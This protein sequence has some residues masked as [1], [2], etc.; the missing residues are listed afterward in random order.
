MLRVI[1]NHR[2]AAYGEA[3]GY[4]GLHDPPRRRSTP[5]AAP[6]SAGRGGA[7]RLGR[8]AGARRAARLP[9]RAGH[10]DRADRHDRPGHGLRHHRDRARLRA[11]EVQE[12]GRRRLLQDHQPD[13]AGGARDARLHARGRSRTSSRYAVGRGTLAGRARHQPRGAARQGLHRRGS[14]E[15]RGA[16]ADAFDIKFAFNPWTLGEELLH[17]RRSASPTRSSTTPAF[18]LLARARLHARARSRP[19]TTFCCGTMTRRGRAAPEGRAPAVFDCANPCGRIGKRFLSAA[20][21]HPD[22]GGGPAVHLAAPSRKTINMPNAATIEDVQGRLHAVLAA[23]PQGATP[24]TATAPSSRQPLA[25][26]AGRRR[27]RT[28]TDEELPRD[29]GQRVA[30]VVERIVEK[31]VRTARAAQAARPP[32]GLHP[33][34]GGRRPQGLPAH[35]RVRGR[36][37]SARSSSTCTRKA[38]PSAR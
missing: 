19:P 9:Q 13:R 3:P 26:H 7:R 2:R 20:E 29:A 14:G 22:D 12:A 11:G 16:L 33:E 5:P 15:G 4:E 28:T 32:Q 24:S 6:T 23:R 38:R 31:V 21:P 35:R 1:R 25:S 37:A 34:G 27:S 17:A 36:H 8:G 18:D 10:G 30:E